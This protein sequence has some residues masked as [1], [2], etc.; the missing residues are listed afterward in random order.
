VAAIEADA[1]TFTLSRPYSQYGYR[2]DQRYYALNLFREIDSPGEWYLDRRTGRI[3]WLPPEGIEAAQAQTVLS[4]F[5]QPFVALDSV[6]HVLFLGLTL[7]EGRGD[8]IHIRGGADC[9][10]ARCTLQRLGGDAVVIEGGQHHG[11]FACAMNTL[12]CGGARVAGG[13]RRTLTPGRHFVENCT[14]SD[15]SRLKRTYT[16]AVHLDGCGNRIAHNLFENMPSSALRVEGNDHLIELNVIRHVVQESDDQGGIDMFGNPLY[17]GVVIRWNR[18]SDIRGGTISGAAGI[19][20]DDM[21]SGVVVQGNIFEHCG[22][23]AFGGLQ[24]HGG[25]D[26][27]V[28]GNFFVD[29]HAGV[30]FSRWGGKRWLESIQ[31][32]VSQASEPLYAKRYPDL[33]GLKEGVDVNFLTRNLFVR[34]GG[35]FLRDGGVER[36]A[37]NA[38]ANAIVT[39]QIASSDDPQ[40]KRTL[41]EPIPVGE[42]GPYESTFGR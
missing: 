32:F 6:A 8:G 37:L 31:R 14:V 9:L 28:D 12:G 39:T 42:M 34:C 18:W 24:I 4:V 35:V 16:P 25:K 23:V 19:R 27:L 7:Q 17:R 5:E 3:Y 1:R 29:C 20:L 15:I 11:V 33:A 21:I 10:V 22:G 13:D 2:K 36:T 40:L 26:N 41:F 38:V 30:S